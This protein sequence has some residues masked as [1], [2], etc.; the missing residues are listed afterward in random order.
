[1]STILVTGGCGFIGSNFINFIFPHRKELGINTLI[2][3]D[4][5]YYCANEKN[6]RKDIRE[7]QIR[8]HLIKGNLCSEDL[9]THILECYKI[10]EVI[11]FAAQSHVQT[12]FSDSLQYTRDNILGTH[13]LLECCR[14]YN[15]I[16]KFIENRKYS[17]FY[18]PL[19]KR[20]NTKK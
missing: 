19:S 16:Q 5:M 11:H 8:Y 6:V 20:V 4:A 15:K 3:L 10:K 12:S 9:V 14:L 18:L 17:H 1:M 2:N 7:N 13:T